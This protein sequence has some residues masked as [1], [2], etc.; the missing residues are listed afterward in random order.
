MISWSTAAGIG[1]GAFEH[2]A[3][4]ARAE[5]DGGDRR[6]P[7]AELAERRARRGD[8]DGV[9]CHGRPPAPRRDGAGDGR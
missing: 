8:D 6:K 5:V 2:L 9:S 4:D 1:A 3:D 7:A